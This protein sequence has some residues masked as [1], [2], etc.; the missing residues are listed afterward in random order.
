MVGLELGLLKGAEDGSEVSEGVEP[1]KGVEEGLGLVFTVGVSV[2]KDV[3]K[4]S[5]VHPQFSNP[6]LKSCV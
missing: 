2:G 3:L 6:M 4:F 1:L 5:Q